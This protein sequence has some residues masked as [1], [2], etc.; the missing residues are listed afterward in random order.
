[1]LTCLLSQTFSSIHHGALFL[2]RIDYDHV[3]YLSEIGAVPPMSV[4]ER[5][6]SDVFVGMV[7]VFR[8]AISL[9][10][11]F[12]IRPGLA[13]GVECVATSPLPER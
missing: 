6:I 11:F 1:M 4:L 7:S 3:E 5:L 9:C 8:V 12:G 10:G 13:P 2:F